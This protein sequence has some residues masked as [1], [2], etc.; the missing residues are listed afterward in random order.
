MLN[1]MFQTDM[2]IGGLC[3]GS[4]RQLLQVGVSADLK[5]KALRIAVT[6]ATL[7][8][9]RMPPAAICCVDW[10]ELQ[11]EMF[12]LLEEHKECLWGQ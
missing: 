6:V 5:F 12:E 7:V 10:Y 2:C 11:T 8:F 9:M 3:N 4:W 1:W